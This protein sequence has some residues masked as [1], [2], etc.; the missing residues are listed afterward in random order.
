MIFCKARKSKAR[1]MQVSAP[2]GLTTQYRRNQLNLALQEFM[3]DPIAK[4]VTAI[5][6]ELSWRFAN[7]AP[8]AAISEEKLFFYTV[9]VGECHQYPFA[10]IRIPTLH[11]NT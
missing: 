3:R 1:V 10:N 2:I 8:T 6:E 9:L 7:Y 4:D 5:T 11:T